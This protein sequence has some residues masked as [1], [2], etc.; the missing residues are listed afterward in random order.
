MTA[1]HRNAGRR[2]PSCRTRPRPSRWHSARPWVGA[3]EMPGSLHRSFDFAPAAL[4]SA[5]SC[6]AL[7]AERSEGSSPRKPFHPPC[8]RAPRRICAAKHLACKILRSAV[9]ADGVCDSRLADGR[10]LQRDCP[11]PERSLAA[12]GMTACFPVSGFRFPGLRPQANQPP[13]TTSAASASH[14]TST[15][16]SRWLRSVSSPSTS[17]VSSA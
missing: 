14:T 6:G 17:A 10:T 11:R 1:V 7:V 5:L 4:R 16:P 13:S 2:R 15:R 9:S 8:R 12:L 3:F